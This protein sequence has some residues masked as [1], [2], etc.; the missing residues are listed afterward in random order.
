MTEIPREAI[1][2]AL[3]T[4]HAIPAEYSKFHPS[5][6]ER[7]ERAIAAAIAKMLPV[8]PYPAVGDQ[9]EVR[10][11]THDGYIWNAATV[12]YMDGF[13]LKAAYPNG[14]SVFLLHD[15]G[16]YRVAPNSRDPDDVNFTTNR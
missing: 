7:M 5:A 3:Q 4:W 16:Q 15:K 2:S 11:A 13:K 8:S 9:I 6:M 10:F 14:K 1:V 12:T